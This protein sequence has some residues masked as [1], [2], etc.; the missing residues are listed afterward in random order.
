MTFRSFAMFRSLVPALVVFASATAARAHFVFVVPDPGGTR[1][2]VILSETLSAD[3]DV[4]VKLAAGTR[5]FARPAGGGP[6]TPVRLDPAAAKDGAYHVD[7]PGGGPRVVYGDAIMGVRQRGD[8]KPHLL[9]YHTKAVVGGDPFDPKAVVGPADAAVELVPVGAPGRVALR[10]LAGGKPVAGGEVTVILPD[11]SQKKVPTDQDGRTPA[12]AAAGRYGAWARHF[13]P[14]TGDHNGKRYEEVR[15]YA[16]LVA[17]VGGGGAAP[18][19]DAGDAPKAAAPAAAAAERFATLPQAASS[20]GAAG[21]GDWLYVYGGHVAK[22]HTYST[23]AVTG[24]FHRLNMADGKTWEELPGGPALQGMNLVAHGGKVYRVGGMQPRN[25]PG[26][27]ADNFSVAD[28][29]RFDPAAN[30]WEPLPPLPEPRSSHDVV[31]VGDTLVVVG[32]WDMRG[33]A[34]GNHWTNTI[35]TLDLTADRLAWKAAEQPFARRALIAAAHGGRVY[36]L[37]GLDEDAAVVRRVDVYD[38]ATGAWSEGPEIPAAA[39]ALKHMGFAPA[40]C[41]A[42]GRLYLSVADGA[43][44]RLDAAGRAWEKVGQATP[45]I[46]H[47][48]V[49]HG[50]KLLVI[51]GAAKG[52]NLDSIEAVTVPADAAAAAAAP[53]AAARAAD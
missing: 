13:E 22:V 47:R 48:L 30:A 35:L 12:F 34:G 51:G 42:G 41:S 5:L 16:M 45:R 18:K 33:R 36:V 40:A 2:K 3:A 37:G 31:A 21:V 14:G 49:S 10:F 32:G 25:K 8:A 24:R 44:L 23:E 7:L 29:A 38:P 53:P 15:R 28:C 39:G 46:V 27:K 1:A 11:G 19:A 43:L 9:A 26:D 6:A 17:D 4:D 50:P 52:D 20:F